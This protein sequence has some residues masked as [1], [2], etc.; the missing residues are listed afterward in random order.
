MRILAVGNIYPPHDFAGGY[1]VTWRS[2]V[3]HLRRHG[4]RVRVLV[5][6]YR[7]PGLD[8]GFELDDDVHRELHWY[9]REHAF[10]RQGLR[11]RLTIERENGAVLRRHLDALRADAVAWWGMGGMSLGLIEHARRR[12]VPA[13][14]VVGDEWMVWGPRADRWLA[15]FKGR[16][17][18]SR[19]AQRASAGPASAHLNPA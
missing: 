14:G 8:A 12:A 5:S 17:R 7:S 19:A 9:W 4:H 10:P 6:D 11:K 1:E 15:P 2:S 18:L 13:V 16:P 3:L